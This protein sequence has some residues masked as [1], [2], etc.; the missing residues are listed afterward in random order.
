MCAKDKI[1]KKRSRAKTFPIIHPDVAGIDIG[2][3]EICVA[4]GADKCEDRVRTFG[5][6][7]SDYHEVVAHLKHYG[8]TSVAMECTGVY[9]VQLFVILE[10]NGI[11]SLV[12][13]ARYV[14]NV[15]GR[16]DDEN[17][18]MWLQ[19]LHSCGL[20]KGSFQLDGPIRELRDLMRNRKKILGDLNRCTNRLIKSL[21]LMNIKVQNVISDID[22]KTGRAIIEAIIEGERD[23][24]KLA[25]LADP[26]I[27]A[28]NEELVKSL[29]GDW[30]ANHLFILK[31]QNQLYNYMIGM[32]HDL[33]LHIEKQ[34]KVVLAYVNGG[35]EIQVDTDQKR[36]RSTG[37]ATPP[38][39]VSAYLNAILGT[40]LTMLP[41]INEI[42]ALTFISEVGTDMSKF[43]DASHLKS[44]L[45]IV[46]VTE[47]TGGKIQKEK[48]KRRFHNAG[49]AL[50]IAANTVRRSNSPFGHIFR[51]NLARGGPSKA[52]LAV[53][54]KMATSIYHMIA[55]REPFDPQR[56]ATTQKK[57]LQKQIRRLEKKIERLR[58]QP[59]EEV[60]I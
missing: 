8:I 40:D 54:D 39:N 22:G 36:K 53:A 4:L 15:S 44:W 5:T 30:N 7:T 38:F 16:K 41:G 17:D 59:E 1:T 46:P 45:N 9:W 6:F 56:Y 28:S 3:A 27:K 48:M 14:K 55:K 18:A 19:R 10:R 47:V 29:E 12:A 42:S 57:D 25:K 49:Q 11:N 52:I 23:P 58:N 33:D 13:N 51:K 32:I 60:V 2:N 24:N 31:Q 50:R 34:L 35:E 21:V 20:I 26:R 43:P 37:K